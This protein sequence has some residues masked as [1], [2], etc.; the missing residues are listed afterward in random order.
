MEG[1]DGRVRLKGSIEGFDGRVRSNVGTAPLEHRG[2]LIMIEESPT[3]RSPE[4]EEPPARRCRLLGDA[5]D[6]E[7]PPEAAPV[8]GPPLAPRSL[9]ARVRVRRRHVVVVVRRDSPDAHAR[10]R[11]WNVPM[12]R[13]MECPTECSMECSM[14]CSIEWSYISFRTT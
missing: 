4:H 1:F 5:G 13:S 9:A 14:E 8:H 6:A 7:E 10:L 12:E 11:T 2:D 3:R